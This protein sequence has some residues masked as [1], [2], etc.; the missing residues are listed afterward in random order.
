[1]E[2]LHCTRVHPE[3]V[4]IIP[5]YRSG[6][7]VDHSRDDW[8]VDVRGNSFTRDGNAQVPVL[9]GMSE[10]DEHSYF[11]GTVFPNAFVDIT[12]TSVIVSFL[13][14]KS[15]DRTTVVTE[16]LFAPSTVAADDFDPSDI[17]EF[18]ELVAGQDYR[19]CEMVQRGVGSKHFTAGVLSPKDE[20]V[21]AWKDRYLATLG[22]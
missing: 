2:C 7:V 13:Q 11:G 15:A 19:V 22:R 18:S 8:G 5:T 9:P 1:M 20:L 3:L 17:V 4:E 6:A 14:P 21:I 16:Y 10:V 12:G